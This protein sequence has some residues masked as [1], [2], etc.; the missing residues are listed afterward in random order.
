M[1]ICYMNLNSLFSLS[2]SSLT[3]TYTHPHT[4]HS[5]TKL[6]IHKKRAVLAESIHALPCGEMCSLPTLAISHYVWLEILLLRISSK[7]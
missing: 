7:T 6:W 5:L 4:P 2:L 3:H 1:R